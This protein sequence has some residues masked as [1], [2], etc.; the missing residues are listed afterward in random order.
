MVKLVFD[1]M[2]YHL[3]DSVVDNAEKIHKSMS[4]MQRGQQYETEEQSSQLLVA[5]ANTQ[6]KTHANKERT[7]FVFL[8]CLLISRTCSPT[9]KS[10]WSNLAQTGQ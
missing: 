8:P 3:G 6:I 7:S 2:K 10:L 5:R 1:Y 4:V 9:N